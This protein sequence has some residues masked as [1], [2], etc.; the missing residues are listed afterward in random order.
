VKF[1]M[2]I[3]L[4]SS[5]MESV[6]MRDLERGAMAGMGTRARDGRAGTTNLV[7]GVVRELH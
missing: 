4:E 3:D 7:M 6:S 1:E 5:E 2:E